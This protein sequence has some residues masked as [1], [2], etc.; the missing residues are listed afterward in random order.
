MRTDTRQIEDGLIELP[1]PLSSQDVVMP[2]NKRLALIR[3]NCLTRKLKR[4]PTYAVK[5]KAFMEDVIAKL[6]PC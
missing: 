1:L 3:L 4:D 6:K 5:Y 2:N